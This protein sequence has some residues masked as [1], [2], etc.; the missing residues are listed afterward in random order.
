M[1]DAR[2]LTAVAALL[3]VTPKA[4]VLATAEKAVR[5]ARETD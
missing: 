4:A 3:T 2:H 1:S 5:A